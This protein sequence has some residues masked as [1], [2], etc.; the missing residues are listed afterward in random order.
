MIL[1][2]ILPA[3]EITVREKDMPDMTFVFK[4]AVLVNVMTFVFQSALKE[5]SVVWS[6]IGFTLRW[7]AFV[8]VDFGF[9]QT[10]TN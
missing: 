3:I 5:V 10:R 6:S 1:V 4:S 7:T 8:D 9:R 2:I